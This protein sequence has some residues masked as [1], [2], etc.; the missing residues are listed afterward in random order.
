MIRIL[1]LIVCN[2]FIA[3]CIAGAGVSDMNAQLIKAA[4]DGNQQAVQSALANGAD[5]NVKTTDGW[6]ALMKASQKGHVEIVKLLL[7]NGADVNVKE[8]R[9][10]TTALYIA[11]YNGHVEIVKLL[12]EKSTDINVKGAGIGATALYI[13]SQKGRVEIVKLLLDKG[14]DVNL[15]TTD[16]TTAL[17]AASEIGHVEIVKLLLDKGADV[18][19]KSTTDGWTALI[20]ASQDGYLRIVEL[21]LAKGADVNAKSTNGVTAL[22]LASQNGHAETVKLLL[23]NSADVN[24]KDTTYGS[25]ALIVAKY[26][27]H[28]EVVQLLEKAGAIVDQNT[29]NDELEKAETSE[30]LEILLK[31]Y[32]NESKTIIPKLEVRA[33]NEIKSKGFGN[34]FVIKEIIS[35]PG[36]SGSLTIEVPPRENLPEGI[37]M[38]SMEFPHDQI[39]I[40]TEGSQLPMGDSSIHRFSGKIKEFGYAF[41]GEGDKLNRL[42]FCLIRDKGYVYLRGK[43]KVIL[44]NGQEVKLG[45]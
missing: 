39:P 16:G 26:K 17:I 13:A 32:P 24:T 34:R 28:K 33:I 40:S 41:I 44:P 11:S 21:L 19:V 9:Y 36:F 2:F 27:N 4:A 20:M 30:E 3:T 12:L 7:D 45:Y 10:G 8:I 18:N 35:Q 29:F 42:T 5:V 23:D 37:R 14:A 31:K 6:T 25:T 15:K 43:G 1:F 38:L 22:Y